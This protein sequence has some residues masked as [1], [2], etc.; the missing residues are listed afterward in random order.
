MKMQFL[1]ALPCISDEEDYQRSFLLHLILSR[2]S[3]RIA[4]EICT[5]CILSNLLVNCIFLISK[6]SNKVELLRRTIKSKIGKHLCLIHV[7]YR[8]HAFFC[9]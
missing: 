7:V 9:A 5:Y 6:Y 1:K 8:M 2:K 4:F 3:L